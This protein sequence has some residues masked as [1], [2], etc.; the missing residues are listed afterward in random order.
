MKDDKLYLAAG[1]EYDVHVLSYDRGS[2]RFHDHGRIVDDETQVACFMP[3]DLVLTPDGV[4]YVGETDHPE[5][6]GYLWECVL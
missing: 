6:S 2:Q 4:A 3:H 1:G 5:R